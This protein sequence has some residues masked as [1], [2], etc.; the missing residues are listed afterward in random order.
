[1]PWLWKNASA[2]WPVS[3]NEKR[4]LSTH[5]GLASDLCLR[6]NDVFVLALPRWR[7]DLGRGVALSLIGQ[8]LETIVEV[9][10]ASTQ[11]SAMFLALSD[12]LEPAAFTMWQFFS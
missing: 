10:F 11:P 9:A 4:C 7:E 2:S 3:A 5:P 6:K 8:L 1:M 12:M